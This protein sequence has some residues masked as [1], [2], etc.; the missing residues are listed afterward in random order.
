MSMSRISRANLVIR[1][2]GLSAAAAAAEAT[3]L[4]CATTKPASGKAVRTVRRVV[5]VAVVIFANSS[6]AS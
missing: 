2:S 5:L 6:F 4:G 3:H 1:S